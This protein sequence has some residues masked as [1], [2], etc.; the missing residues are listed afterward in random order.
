M[1]INSILS[2]HSAM[3]KLPETYLG[4]N[5]WIGKLGQFLTLAAFILALASVI[6]YGMAEVRRKQDDQASFWSKQGKIAFGLH[7]LSVIGIFGLLLYMIIG[8]FYEYDYVYSHSS[9]SLPLKYV[10]SAFWE[11]Q[12]GSFLLWIFWHSILGLCLMRWTGKWEYPTMLVVSIAQVLLLSMVLGI[13]VG[14]TKIGINPFQLLREKYLHL[15]L[16]DNYLSLITDGEGLN[17]LLQNYWMVIHPPVLFLGFASTI[18]PFAFVLG[19]IWREDQKSWMPAALPWALFAAGALG[20]GIF[21]GGAWAYE[22]LSFGGFWAWDPVENASLVPWLLLIAGLHTLLIARHTGRQIGLTYLLLSLG[23]ILVAYSTYLTRSGVLTDTSAH[24]FVDAGLNQHLIVFL[25]II[26]LPSLALVAYG[27]KM[28]TK[29]PGEEALLSREFW[30]FVGSILFC[31]SAVVIAITTSFPVINKV[32]NTAY[33]IANPEEWYNNSQMVLGILLALLSAFSQFLVYKVG[34]PIKQLKPTLLVSLPA[35]VVLTI[36]LGTQYEIDFISAYSWGSFISA[37]WLLLWSGILVSLTNTYYL[38]AI[39][40]K[41][42]KTWGSSLSHIGFG[43]LLVGIIISQYRQRVLTEN[44]ISE[45]ELQVFYTQN[46]ITDLEEQEQYRDFFFTTLFMEE[47]QTYSLEDYKVEYLGSYQ[48]DLDKRYFKF[49]FTDNT[50]EESFIVEPFWQTMDEMGN[51]ASNPGTKHFLLKDVF[52]TVGSYTEAKAEKS[53]TI[54]EGSVQMIGENRAVYNSTNKESMLF[55]YG[56]DTI[57]QYQAHLFNDIAI[58]VNR[59]TLSWPNLLENR[60]IY[61]SYSL[62]DSASIE[63]SDNEISVIQ[64]SSSTFFVSRLSTDSIVEVQEVILSDG[65]RIDTVRLDALVNEA[66]RTSQGQLQQFSVDRESQNL[67]ST[68]YQ[69]EQVRLEAV[70]FPQIKLIWLGGILMMGGLLLSAGFRFTRRS[71]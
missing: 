36:A 54:V 44:A 65:S 1:Q 68:I 29:I 22:S 69:P 62:D 25:A 9:R 67:S 56:V 24:S 32:F 10:I 59:G 64:S 28:S 11:G 26:S 31:L 34:R 42:W 4:E 18:I 3:H 23:F 6:L 50:S 27:W 8:Q 57:E 20:T 17:A 16:N 19:A 52:T 5:I 21:M 40:Q 51:P 49:Q 35:S 33:S 15:A 7:A 45:G 38:T 61:Q 66:F 55:F 53:T 30:L 12:E 39:Q 71:M 46:N 70:V 2:T 58:S 48:G 41:R 13:H 63:W 60:L 43:I 47:N 14:S 37:Y